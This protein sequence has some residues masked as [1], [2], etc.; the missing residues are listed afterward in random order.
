TNSATAAATLDLYAVD[1]TTGS[2]SGAVFPNRETP[3]KGPGTWLRLGQSQVVVPPNGTQSVDVELR[4]P[5]DAPPGQ[6]LAGIA[7]QPP[8]TLRLKDE[9]GNVRAT[10]PLQMDTILPG[11]SADF[12]VG[13]PP[14]L[15]AGDYRAD[16]TL[17]A[18]DS[19]PTGPGAA[20]SPAQSGA[21]ATPHAELSS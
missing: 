12:T 4:V 19:L 2:T 7:A 21:A 11:G 15:P 6:Y 18:V 10:V 9:A 17:D 1:A 8:G 14:D 3:P 16:V 5:A 20:G 13:W